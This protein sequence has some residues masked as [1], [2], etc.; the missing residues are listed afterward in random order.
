M[1]RFRT[2]RG[3]RCGR[4]ATGHFLGWGFAEGGKVFAVRCTSPD[5]PIF[6]ITRLKAEANPDATG[7][8]EPGLALVSR[9]ATYLAFV[10]WIALPPPSKNATQRGK[11]MVGI[12]EVR[13]GAYYAVTC[14]RRQR[15]RME[16][17]MDEVEWEIVRADIAMEKA[18][19]EAN[20]DWAKWRESQT[21]TNLRRAAL[22]APADWAARASQGAAWTARRLGWRWDQREGR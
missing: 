20:G 22:V 8:G 18:R 16:G 5:A 1:N 21:R 15:F 11:Q 17:K 12:F 6:D 19:L 10:R 3:A 7:R 13:S 2:C 9:I 14:T 4:A